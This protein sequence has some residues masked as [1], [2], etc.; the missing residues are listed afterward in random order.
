MPFSIVTPLPCDLLLLFPRDGNT[1]AMDPDERHLAQVG[2]GMQ[3]RFPSSAMSPPQGWHGRE[4]DGKFRDAIT[5]F[6]RSIALE[7]KES[8]A[9][10][11]R[12]QTYMSLSQIDKARSISI[13]RSSS[14]RRTIRRAPREGSRCC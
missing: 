12:G 8:S 7:P 9:F 1:A 4:D 13:R 11:E 10:T 2:Q 14:I 3:R 6:D 5:D